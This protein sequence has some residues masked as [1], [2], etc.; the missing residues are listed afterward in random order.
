MS[1][2]NQKVKVRG[3]LAQNVSPMTP[4]NVGSKWS[5]RTFPDPKN[6]KWKYFII[7]AFLGN[8]EPFPLAPLWCVLAQN[9]SP[10]TP[11]NVGSKWSS[12]TF[13]DP[14]KVNKKKFIIE[15]F[16]TFP[17]QKN[18]KQ[19]KV[20]YEALLGQI[21]RLCQNQWSINFLAPQYNVLTQV[22]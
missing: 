10:M 11:P 4:P 5:Y 12:K 8:I 9:V 20:I 13:S 19:K 2:Q 16:P 7:E 17:D 22:Q 15:A 3:F 14:K 18:G 1:P 6:K 21:L